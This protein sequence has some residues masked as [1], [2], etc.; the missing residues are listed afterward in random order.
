[1]TGDRITAINTPDGAFLNVKKTDSGGV[2]FTAPGKKPFTFVI[3]TEGGHNFSIR[4]VPGSGGGRTVQLVSE[5]VGYSQTENAWERA[6]PY[7]TLLLSLNREAVQGKVP[8][9]YSVIPVTNETLSTPAGLLARAERVWRGSQLTLVRFSVLNTGRT[10][11]SVA[12]GDF[13]QPGIRAVM[14]AQPVK[15]LLA[16]GQ[17]QLYVTRANGGEYGKH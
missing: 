3:E 2:V 5:L 11:V 7:E 17:M 8:R 16:G 15:T 4:A 10:A 14:F 1:M 12:E 9:G 6:Q 13:W